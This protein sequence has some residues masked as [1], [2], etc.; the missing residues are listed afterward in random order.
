MIQKIKNSI[1]A[2][3]LVG[4]ILVPLL[5]PATVVYAQDQIQGGLNCGANLDAKNVTSGTPNCPSGNQT[6]PGQ[7]VNDIIK[8]VINIFSL[9]V[10]VV[11]VIM[12][13]VGGL[14][15]IT[16]GGDSGNVTGAKN[17]ILYAIIGLVVVAL[18]QFIVRFVLSK[19]TGQTTP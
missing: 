18:A 12:I 15:Y 9:V 19:V 16:S 3:L 1:K 2:F 5:S 8:L 14:K 6:D 11:A 10:G 17:T 7:K 13:I 4:V